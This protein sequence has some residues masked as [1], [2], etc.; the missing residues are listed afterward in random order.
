MQKC[1]SHP[2]KKS[3]YHQVIPMDVST[4]SATGHASPASSERLVDV[5]DQGSPQ[6]LHGSEYRRYVERCA[7]A[8]LEAMRSRHPKWAQEADRRKLCK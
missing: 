1:L 7:K 3:H 6:G 4:N 2:V 5:T 8:E